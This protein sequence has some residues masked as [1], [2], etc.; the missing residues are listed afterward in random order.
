MTTKETRTY[1]SN[2]KHVIPVNY[3]LFRDSVED[4][5]MWRLI[6]N[7]QTNTKSSLC[8]TSLT[9]DSMDIKDLM[10]FP[11]SNAVEQLTGRVKRIRIGTPNFI[12]KFGKHLG[13]QETMIPTYQSYR[14]LVPNQE[15][16]FRYLELIG[17]LNLQ[18]NDL[19]LSNNLLSVVLKRE[20]GLILRR[21]K[22]AVEFQP[23]HTW[24][25]ACID[26]EPKIIYYINLNDV[27]DRTHFSR[28]SRY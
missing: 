15:S 25:I 13:D 16:F 9:T 27:V 22:N 14:L 12:Q 24:T 6:Q 1:H 8:D 3:L 4:S 2:D 11:N 21:F 18:C 28:T 5:L 23:R 26:H 10:Y 20:H 19:E 7:K 17:F